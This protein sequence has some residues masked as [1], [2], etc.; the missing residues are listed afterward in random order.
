MVTQFNIQNNGFKVVS[1]ITELVN[2]MITL[3]LYDVHYT[4]YIYTRRG[5]EAGG[6]LGVNTP[7][8][9]GLST[10]TFWR[11]LKMG[12]GEGAQQKLGGLEKNLG[13]KKILGVHKKFRGGKKIFRRAKKFF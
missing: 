1:C 10:P 12:A 9:F 3:A 5:A 6:I 2:T 4:I 11:D 13:G 8:F 7:H